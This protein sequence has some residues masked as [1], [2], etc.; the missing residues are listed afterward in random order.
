M[1]EQS[2][3]LLVGTHAS[4]FE[5]KFGNV[6]PNLEKFVPLGIVVSR[7]GIYPKELIRDL[8]KDLCT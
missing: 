6:D 3:D 2:H 1:N 7:L 4:T 5:G 8:Y